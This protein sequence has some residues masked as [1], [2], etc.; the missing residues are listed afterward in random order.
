MC[1][2]GTLES[3]EV[4][5][6]AQ[7][8]VQKCESIATAVGGVFTPGV[9]DFDHD[10]SDPTLRMMIAIGQ[11]DLKTAERLLNGKLDPNAKYD[12]DSW[13]DEEETEEA[14]DDGSDSLLVLAAEA[15]ASEFCKLLID[16][17]AN[18][19]PIYGS[20]PAL[21]YAA[22]AGRQHTVATLKK[23][24]DRRF[25]KTASQMLRQSQR[26]L[27][28]Q[29]MISQASYEYARHSKTGVAKL[30][31]ALPVLAKIGKLPDVLG[32]I[33]GPAC[34]HGNDQVVQFLLQNGAKLEIVDKSG[35]TPLFHA[36]CPSVARALIDA[37]ANVRARDIFKN[38]PLG[39]VNEPESMHQLLDGGANAKSRDWCGTGMVLNTA[40]SMYRR[41]VWKPGVFKKSAAECDTSYRTVLE[42]L[43]ENG[44][45]I[46]QSLPVDGTTALMLIA[47]M[48][49]VQ[50]ARFLIMCGEDGDAR[51][52]KGKSP[53]DY[54]KKNTNVYNLLKT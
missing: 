51:D 27:E 50:S 19:N 35:A 23:H 53:R 20:K 8:V 5:G 34:H 52:K 44:A 45:K 39:S 42:R 33:L 41:K 49:L 21:L 25:H 28:Q 47:E 4:I 24:T 14:M 1:L 32:Q 11:N 7:I 43:V 38:T 29:K 17:G 18:A 37:G 40:L 22:E 31:S 26:T 16:Y 6:D 10:L 36:H 30:E 2:V 48:N 12:P 13:D 54:A 15:G 3:I 46:N 9:V